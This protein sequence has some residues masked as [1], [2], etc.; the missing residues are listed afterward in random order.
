MYSIVAVGH[1]RRRD[2]VIQVAGLQAGSAGASEC[3]GAGVNADEVDQSVSVN[4]TCSADERTFV[5]MQAT[6]ATHRNVFH[7][8]ILGRVEDRLLASEWVHCV[9]ASLC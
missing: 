8:A 1:N 9:N 5:G 7:V 6:V 2:G 3:S 4:S